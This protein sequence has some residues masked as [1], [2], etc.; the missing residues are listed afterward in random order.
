MRLLSALFAAGLLLAGAA[1]CDNSTAKSG[2][3]AP[4]VPA[5]KVRLK[6]GNSGAPPAPAPVPLPR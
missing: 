6:A 4:G 3:A 5:P 2:D 1:G